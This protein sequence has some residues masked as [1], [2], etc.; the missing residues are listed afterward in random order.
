MCL[1]ES[2]QCSLSKIQQAKL[3][4]PKMLLYGRYSDA[5]MKGSH[6]KLQGLVYVGGKNLA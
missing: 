6:V 3:G 1:E 2:F 5:M 4:V